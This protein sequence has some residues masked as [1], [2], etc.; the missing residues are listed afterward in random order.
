MRSAAGGFEVKF[1]VHIEFRVVG[2]KVIEADTEEDAVDR[3]FE[4]FVRDTVT[5]SEDIEA[6]D[7][8]H[9]I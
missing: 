9:S 7:V 1:K 6:V 2:W 4:L 3:A 5:E 8:E